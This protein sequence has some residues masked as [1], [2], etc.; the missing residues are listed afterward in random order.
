M[1]CVS[2]LVV[3]GILMTGSV[4]AEADLSKLPPA[5]SKPGVT[6]E[7][8]V[9]P[10][11]KASCVGCHG[12][13]RPKAGL[14]LD[15][16]ETVLKGSK[17][18]KVVTV[19]DSKKSPLVVAAS[20]I[21]PETAMPPTKRPRGPGGP[22]GPGGNHPPGPEGATNQPPAGGPPRGMQGPP[23]KPLTAEQVGL[24]RAWIDQGAK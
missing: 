19:G 8:D 13:Q 4:F 11:F 18:G 12:A 20:R 16:L 6:F 7:N 23:P 5:S 17:D 3:A 1:K 2:T 15:S 22:G 9:L 21:D 24:L 14:R 10:M